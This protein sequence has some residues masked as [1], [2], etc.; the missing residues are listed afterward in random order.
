MAAALGSMVCRWTIGRSKFAEVE[1]HMQATLARSEALRV[2]LAEMVARDAAAVEALM[3]AYRLP[4]GSEAA[5]AA[6]REAIQ[7][8]A[9]KAV[10]SP[11]AIAWACVEVIE[12]GRTAASLGNPHALGDARAGIICAQAGLQIAAMD[13]LLNLEIVEDEVF[14]ANCRTELER[15]MANQPADPFS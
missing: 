1:A 13:V 8:G 7:A 6:R 11:L 3:A 12:L 10:L 15:I 5:Q 2:K 4:K 9:K 14:A